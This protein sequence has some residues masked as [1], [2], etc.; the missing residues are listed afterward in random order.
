[1]LY[2]NPAGQAGGILKNGGELLS[3]DKDYLLVITSAG[4]GA[5]APDL[6]AKLAEVFFGVLA[7]SP[8]RPAKMIFLNSG[9]LLTTAG[10]PAEDQL[11][12]LEEEGTEIS[13]C[14]TCLTYFD[15]M[16]KV[17]VGE[18]SNMKE[19]VSSLAGFKKVVTI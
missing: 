1:L 3:I 4:I 8:S 19:T 10:S 12:K 9:I 16:E 7:E 11:K 6:G 14:I 15:R 13:S 18:R 2:T 5:G 17:V